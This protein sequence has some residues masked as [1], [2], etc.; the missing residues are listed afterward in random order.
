M[1]QPQLRQFP[2]RQVLRDGA[3]REHL[4]VVGDGSQRQHVLGVLRGVRDRLGVRHRED[5]GEAATGGRAG[6]RLHGFGVLASRFTQVGV[7]VHQTGQ[8]DQPVR[9]DGGRTQGALIDEAARFDE[10]V[11]SRPVGQGHSGDGEFRH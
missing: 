11:R 4:A 6:T 9:V 1:H 2:A 5:S 10:Q 7:D 8:R 3:D